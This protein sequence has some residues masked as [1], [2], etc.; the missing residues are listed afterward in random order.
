MPSDAPLLGDNGTLGPRE[1]RSMFSPD[2][3]QH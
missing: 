1:L 3:P 2:E